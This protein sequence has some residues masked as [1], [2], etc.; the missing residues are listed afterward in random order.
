MI[1]S[2]SY[3]KYQWKLVKDPEIRQGKLMASQSYYSH[4]IDP[5]RL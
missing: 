3:R 5:T 2:T 1:T 4:T